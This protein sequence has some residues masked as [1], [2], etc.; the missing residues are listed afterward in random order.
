MKLWLW[1][2]GVILFGACLF[3]GYA[4]LF[5]FGPRM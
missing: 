4:L 5:A 2:L 1:I 3:L